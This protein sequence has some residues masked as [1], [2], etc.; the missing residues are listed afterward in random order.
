MPSIRPP[1]ISTR[2]SGAKPEKGDMHRY[3][4][5]SRKPLDKRILGIVPRALPDRSIPTP[6][7][8]SG[9]DLPILDHHNC[10]AKLHAHDGVVG[11]WEGAATTVLTIGGA[12]C[13]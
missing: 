7:T 12:R 3:H 11:A 4:T 1:R 2:A 13:S 5:D 8:V 9:D 6:V 10:F